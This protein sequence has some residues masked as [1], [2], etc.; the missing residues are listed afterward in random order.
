MY[1]GEQYVNNKTLADVTFIVE[2]REF[3]AHRIAL[4]A[5]SDHFR[6]MFGSGFGERDAAQVGDSSGG[7]GCGSCG[8]QVDVCIR[9]AC[10]L[11]WG[12]QALDG[13]LLGV[14]C[15]HAC[16]WAAGAVPVAL[17]RSRCRTDLHASK[18]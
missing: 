9:P 17:V 4:L 11:L 14:L 2:G 5:S 13:C 8:K 18:V 1:L 12:W 10:G 7:G 3:Y 6:A 15:V 16:T